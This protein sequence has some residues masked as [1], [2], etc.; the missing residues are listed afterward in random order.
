[1]TVSMRCET[2]QLIDIMQISSH[3][4]PSRLMWCV[5]LILGSAVWANPVDSAAGRLEAAVISWVAKQQGMSEAEVSMVPLDPRLRVQGCQSNLGLDFPFSSAQTVR[6]RCSQPNWQLFVRVNLGQGSS[7]V[8]AAG[9]SSGASS[10]SGALRRVWVVD[11]HV[12]TGSPVNRRQLVLVDKE[13]SLVGGGALDP[14]ADVSYLEAVRDLAPGSIVRQHDLRPVTL[15]KR[16]QMVQ[17]L[18]GQGQGFQIAARVEA[19]QDGRFGE[20][21]KLKNPESGRILSGVVRG[22]GT[23]DGS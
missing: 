1:M 4:K 7:S 15:V 18:I 8:M 19:L 9:Q 21:I 16:G 23:V 10:V 20:Q 12:T 14:Q 22:P 6:V 17:I 2:V 13:S 11:Q 5:A 3:V